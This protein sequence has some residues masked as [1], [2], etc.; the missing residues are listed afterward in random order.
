MFY[1]I[2]KVLDDV[3]FFIFRKMLKNFNIIWNKNR[4]KFSGKM[5]I[6]K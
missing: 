6:Y 5:W 4:Y 2:K 3:R 1:I